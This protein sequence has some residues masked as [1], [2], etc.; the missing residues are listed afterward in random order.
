[1]SYS[2]YECHLFNTRP[3]EPVVRQRLAILRH[4][5]D[6]LNTLDRLERC[7]WAMKE[8]QRTGEADQLEIAAAWLL[9]LWE[10]R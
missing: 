4:E 7:Q 6:S 8:F 10:G 9:D 5:E 3:F 1:M 2:E